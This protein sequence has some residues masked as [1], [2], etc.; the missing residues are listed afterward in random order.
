MTPIKASR[1]DGLLTLFFQKYWHTVGQDIG[2]FC[3][4]VLNGGTSLKEINRTHI[5]LIPKIT[6]QTS[7]GLV[8]FKIISKIVVNQFQNVLNECIDEAQS[9]FVLRRLITYNIL[10]AFELLNS[11][12]QKRTGQKG[13]FAL[14]LDMSKAYDRV[15]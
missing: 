5:V 11:F 12:K 1:L 9:A 13:L 2:A 8:L 4:E 3:L 10:L 14:K 7:L 6:N 15:E